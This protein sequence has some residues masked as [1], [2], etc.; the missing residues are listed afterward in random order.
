MSAFIQKNIYVEDAMSV[1]DLWSRRDILKSSIA[2]AGVGAVGLFARPASA[3]GSLKLGASDVTVISDG[4]LMLPLSFAF[5]DVSQDELIAFLSQQGQ[6]TDALLPDCN[7][8]V[9]R[10]G[11]RVVMFDVGSGP[12]FMPSAGKLMDNLEEAGVSPDEVTDIVFTHAHPDH[13][14]GL[15]DDFDELIFADA[16]YHMN[17][18]EWDYWRADDTLEK[19]PE[20]RKSFVV[21]AQNRMAFLE[22]RIELFEYGAEVVPGVEAV[23]TS[24]HTPGHTSFMIHDGS[25]SA[26]VVGDAITNVAV[27]LAHPEWPSGSDQDAEKG[28]ATRKMLLDRLATDGSR[29]IG[30]HMPHPGLGTVERAG[31]AYRFVVAG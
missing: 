27:S 10:H 14:W 30:F 9:F 22:D 5:P 6:P 1:N 28:I 12:N 24:G 7:I 15:I 4:N 23:D 2:L 21:G 25:N 16:R 17:R 31:T 26:L 19:T 18:V 20:A 3:L 29:I 11:D 13:L 8:T